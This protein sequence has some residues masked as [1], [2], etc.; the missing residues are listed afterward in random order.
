MKNPEASQ[1]PT[2]PY[3]AAS[4]FEIESVLGIAHGPMKYQKEEKKSIA[5]IA[6][7]IRRCEFTAFASLLSIIKIPTTIQADPIM[8]SA[9]V[10][11]G[12]TRG[13]SQLKSSHELIVY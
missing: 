7:K 12:M 9:P 1:V 13:A 10:K 3:P 4:Q 11:C 6:S 5:L 2:V 8:E